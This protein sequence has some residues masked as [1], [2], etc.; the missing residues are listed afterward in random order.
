MIIYAAIAGLLAM[1]G[2]ITWYASLDNPKLETAEIDLGDVVIV[3]V[4][5]IDRRA[6]L[7]VGFKIKNPSDK[8]FTI[9]NISYE[10]YGNGKLLGKGQYSNEDVPLPGR[11]IFSTNVEIELPSRFQLIPTTENADV[12]DA[13]VN[14]EPVQYSA[15][16]M[17]TVESAWSLVEK[18][19]DISQ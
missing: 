10:L 18:Q 4:N 15:K 9:S 2:G 8:P 14:R 6:S 1:L 7:D 12:Y 13:I 16:G 3:N 19:F 5:S 17:M 11:A